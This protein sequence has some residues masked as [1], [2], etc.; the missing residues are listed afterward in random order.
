MKHTSHTSESGNVLWFI[1]VA[2]ILLGALTLML[3]RAGSNVEQSGDFEQ[4]RIKAT[5]LMRYA[6]SIEQGIDKLRHI[7]GC[8]ENEISFANTTD[9]NYNNTN[10]P[11]DNSCHIFEPEGAGLEWRSLTDQTST[12]FGGAGLGFTGSIEVH[13]LE[14]TATELVAM[15]PISQSLCNHINSKFSI[16]TTTADITSDMDDLTSDYYT[17][18]FVEAFEF[19]NGATKAP[20]VEDEAT[21][22]IIDDNGEYLFYHVLLAR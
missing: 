21:G 10:S 15:I 7:N 22:C 18:S 9:T 4:L 8:S 1:L 14:T 16:S 17:G 3:S 6:S 11:T 13:D 12:A 19:G 20:G 5:Q 2:V